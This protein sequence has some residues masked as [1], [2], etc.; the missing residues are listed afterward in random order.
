M[1][2]FTVSVSVSRTGILQF[3]AAL[4]KPFTLDEDPEEL[5]KTLEMPAS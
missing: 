3:R 5:L 4:W 2:I 1:H